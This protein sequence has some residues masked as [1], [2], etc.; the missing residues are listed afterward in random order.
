LKDL[1]HISLPMGIIC[2]VDTDKRRRKNKC[3]KTCTCFLLTYAQR[4]TAAPV[5][6]TYNDKG[7]REKRGS[8]DRY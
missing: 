2:F 8:Y 6:V 5:I 4:V 7:G 3:K 1:A